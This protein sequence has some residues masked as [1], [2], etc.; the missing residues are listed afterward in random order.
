MFAGQLACE[1]FNWGLKRWIKEA[2][3]K[4]ACP[5]SDLR[6]CQYVRE[7]YILVYTHTYVLVI[8]LRVAI[9]FEREKGRE[10]KEKEKN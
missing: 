10:R 2:R 3:P 4:R 7:I 8:N 5:F 6:L 9:Q 1:A